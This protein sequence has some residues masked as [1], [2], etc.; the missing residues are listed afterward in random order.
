MCWA[1]YV[2]TE[3]VRTLGEPDGRGFVASTWRWTA[4]VAELASAF[5]PSLL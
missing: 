2:C 1:T 3:R 4:A 5:T